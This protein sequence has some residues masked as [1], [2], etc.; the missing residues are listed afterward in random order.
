MCIGSEPW[1]WKEQT[2]MN[3]FTFKERKTLKTA[4]KSTPQNVFLCVCI[5]IKHYTQ[6]SMASL[7]HIVNLHCGTL[8]QKELGLCGR[9]LVEEVVFHHSHSSL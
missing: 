4:G 5:Y 1:R 8:A 3:K 6:R 2:K 7:M 9:E